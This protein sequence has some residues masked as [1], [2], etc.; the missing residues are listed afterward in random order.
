MKCY[1]CNGKTQEGRWWDYMGKH[2]CGCCYLAMEG[3]AGHYGECFDCLAQLWIGS[4]NIVDM[5]NT[6]SGEKRIACSHCYWDSGN[7]WLFDG[8]DNQTDEEDISYMF[9]D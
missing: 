6:Y 8:W 5:I 7:E 2:Y 9:E 1:K 4:T 3:T